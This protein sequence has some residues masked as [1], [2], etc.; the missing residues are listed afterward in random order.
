MRIA[1]AI[2][3]AV[4]AMAGCWSAPAIADAPTVNCHDPARGIVQRVYSHQCKG[5]VVD[6]AEAE[7]LRIDLERRRRV[8][9]EEASAEDAAIEARG[10]R[11]ASAGAGFIVGERGEAL[12]SA[13]VIDGCDGVL[14]RDPDRKLYDG[15][16]LRVDRAADLALLR[17]A[18][19]PPGRATFAPDRPVQ[20]QPIALVGFPHE[21]MIPLEPRLT[22]VWAAYDV[23]DPRATGL[24]GVRGDVRRG[25]SGGPAFDSRGELVGLL[26]AKVD[27]V[28]AARERGEA[29]SRM[30]VLVDVGALRSFL[31]EAH[32][33]YAQA[34]APGEEMSGRAIFQRARE[35]ILR[36]ECYR[37]AQ[38]SP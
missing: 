31:D 4:T 8:R 21:G 29:L 17:V 3:G 35:G 11:L 27:S 15:T 13:H 30:G 5:A 1:R 25:H 16:V 12:T 26:R 20:D 9:A 14:L 6:D 37:S 7:A 10:L 22:P 33:A 36:I 34:Q 28:R 2:L 18:D 23:A 32:V 38:S 24:L 19:P